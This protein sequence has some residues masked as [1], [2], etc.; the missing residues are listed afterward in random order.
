MQGSDVIS[1]AGLDI[2]VM[3]TRPNIP[4]GAQQGHAKQERLGPQTQMDHHRAQPRAHKNCPS[5]QDIEAV[6]DP[7]VA[8]GLIDN[9]DCMT[10]P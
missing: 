5:T 10:S 7:A 3:V 8:C 2:Y 6:A 1:A 9:F 4:A